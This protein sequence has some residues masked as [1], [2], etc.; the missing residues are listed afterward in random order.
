MSFLTVA[1]LVL[2]IAS[3]TLPEVATRKRSM[4]MTGVYKA[5]SICLGPVPMSTLKGSNI[6]QHNKR[7]WSRN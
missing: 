4:W 7:H 5:C 6:W 3:T 2:Q 1:V